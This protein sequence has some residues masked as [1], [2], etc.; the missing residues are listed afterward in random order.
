MTAPAPTEPPLDQID[1]LAGLTDEQR[2]DMLRAQQQWA[3]GD[4]L[5]PRRARR[6]ALESAIKIV[7]GSNAIAPS[8]LLRGALAGK[9]LDDPDVIAED[10]RL[11]AEVDAA[12][13]KARSARQAAN[14]H[15]SYLRDRPSKYARVSYEMLRPDQN[16][17]GMVTTWLSRGPR[18]L[19]LAGSSRT[20]KS[21]AAYAI[22]NDAHAQQKWVVATTAVALCEACKPAERDRE[23][24]ADVYVPSRRDPNAFARAAMC[25]LLLL[26]DFG[27]EPVQRSSWWGAQIQELLDVRETRELRTI[28]TANTSTDPNRAYDELV[29]RYG[30]PVVERIIDGGGI[31][32]FDGEP[33]RNLVTDW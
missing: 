6:A 4:E 14:R 7:T 30:D 20:G 26:D 19:L 17:R 15:A 29:V 25:D 11:R 27:R 23:T 3:A 8:A 21:T 2:A 9:S 33:I 24:S 5:A 16:P 31:I 12:E 22:A 32:I 1:P 18:A 10:K 13:H 28:F